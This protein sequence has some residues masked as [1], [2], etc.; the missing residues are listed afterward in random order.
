MF[1]LHVGYVN[2]SNMRSGLKNEVQPSFFIVIKDS[3]GVNL[4][5]IFTCK[6]RLFH[7]EP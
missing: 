4:F 3:G 1:V 2:I 6:E 7:W 5:G